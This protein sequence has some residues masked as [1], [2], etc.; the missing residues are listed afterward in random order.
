[1]KKF[2]K[3][4]KESGLTLIELIVALGI[5]GLVIGM[6]SGILVLALMS[7]RRITA[8]RNV[9][10]NIR[11][12]TESMA[13]EIRTGKNFNTSGN[14]LSFTNANGESIV[15]RLNNECD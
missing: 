4:N 12:A 5:F 14:L 9:E 15:Y 2:K 1:M 11:F 7:Q 8:L 13:R 10:D 3:I 6:V